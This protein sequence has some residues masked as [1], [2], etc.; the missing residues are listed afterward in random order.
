MYGVIT[1]VP[2]PVEM[3]DALHAEMLRRASTSVEGLLVHVGRATVDGF[4][5]LEVWESEEHYD[6]ANSAIVLPV[7]RELAGDQPLPSMDQTTEAFEVHGLVV[8]RGNIL[9]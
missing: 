6:R 3:Y 2:A 9:I 1:T 8:P 5:T 4:Q 7:L